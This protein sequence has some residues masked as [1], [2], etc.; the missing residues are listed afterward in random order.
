MMKHPEH[1]NQL[2]Q[3]NRI[4]G[5]LQGVKKMI[6]EGRYCMDILMQ[7][8]A[9]ESSLRSLERKILDTHLHGCVYQAF[10]QPLSQTEAEKKI[11]EISSFLKTFR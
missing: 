4:I 1:R 7:A 11:E 9:A 5:Q 8:K 3:L 2:K 10:S 6:E